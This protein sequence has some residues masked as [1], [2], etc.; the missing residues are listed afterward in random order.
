[1]PIGFPWTDDCPPLKT[2]ASV[3]G[4][5][6]DE[7]PAE[8]AATRDPVTPAVVV[9]ATIRPQTTTAFTDPFNLAPMT[10]P[11][12]TFQTLTSSEAQRVRAAPVPTERIKLDYLRRFEDQ[13]SP[14]TKVTVVRREHFSKKA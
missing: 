1:M 6:G 14:M 7:A 13:S 5:G 8:D 11:S 3:P 4:A 9:A 2:T 12:L 10:L